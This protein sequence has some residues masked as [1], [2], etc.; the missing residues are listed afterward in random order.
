M[1]DTRENI[2]PDF[3]SHFSCKISNKTDA[4][5]F[6]F[7]VEELFPSVKSHYWISIILNWTKMKIGLK[8]LSSNKIKRLL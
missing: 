6:T 4:I 2:T 7:Y 8:R 5:T 1:T 3:G